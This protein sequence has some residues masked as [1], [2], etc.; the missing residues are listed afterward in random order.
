MNAQNARLFLPLVQAVM[1]GKT[2]EFDR[3]FGKS[4]PD[5][6]AIHAPD[7]CHAP[8]LYRIKPEPPKP[9]EF[10]MWVHENG[11]TA[12]PSARDERLPQRSIDS[13]WVEIKVR[14]VLPETP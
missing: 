5:W 13:G 11:S 14:E 12:I 7:F 10:R 8:E 9:R 1:D 2:I 4:K 6:T 3:N